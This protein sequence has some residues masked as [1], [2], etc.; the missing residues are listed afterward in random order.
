MTL[1]SEM[2]LVW[3]LTEFYFVSFSQS[4]ISVKKVF[5]KTHIL[6]STRALEGCLVK[7]IKGLSR[8]VLDV[9]K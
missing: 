7:L 1:A 6:A 5:S 3:S 9:S 2:W 4:W 8:E